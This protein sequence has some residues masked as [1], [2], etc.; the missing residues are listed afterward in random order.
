M[1]DCGML[2]NVVGKGSGG[3][4]Y[5]ELRFGQERCWMSHFQLMVLYVCVNS[6]IGGFP[7]TCKARVLLL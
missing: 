6:Q 3:C 7:A 5:T 1:V 4:L 2:R